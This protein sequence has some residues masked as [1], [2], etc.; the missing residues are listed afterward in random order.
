M[1][2]DPQGGACVMIQSSDP[3]QD[4][5]ETPAGLIL[6]CHK[7]LQV[8]LWSTHIIS[9]V[10]QRVT[11]SQHQTWKSPDYNNHNKPLNVMMKIWAFCPQ[12]VFFY[13]QNHVKKR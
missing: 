7:T 4:V 2:S 3:V 11:K 1:Y 6:M 10:Q 13:H 9:S 5:S 8:T 12:M